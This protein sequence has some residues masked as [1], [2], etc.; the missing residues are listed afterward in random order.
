VLTEQVHP[1]G[2]VATALADLVM[3]PIDTIKTVQQALP[4]VCKI[5]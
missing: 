5:L 2:G 1:Q 3:H 4:A